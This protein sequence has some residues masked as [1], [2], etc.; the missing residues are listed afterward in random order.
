[1]LNKYSRL[2]LFLPALLAVWASFGMNDFGHK[3]ADLKRENSLQDTQV[4]NQI[5]QT[6]LLVK[7]S[8]IENYNSKKSLILVGIFDQK[9]FENAIK[10]L[11]EELQ[12]K[13]TTWLKAFVP[14]YEKHLILAKKETTV[15]QKLVSVPLCL[16]ILTG[17]FWF[18]TSF[19]KKISNIL[20]ITSLV[21]LAGG[22]L[23]IKIYSSRLDALDKQLEQLV[24]PP[25][26]VQKF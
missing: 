11:P 4:N 20:G 2:T 17:L 6:K 21:S 8:T 14:K 13:E 25:E 18:G 1:M 15:T 16:S 23:G 9:T 7:N 22:I 19:P 24:Y 3:V 5:K 10:R 26:N 12:I